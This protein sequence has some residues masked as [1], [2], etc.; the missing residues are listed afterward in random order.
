MRKEEVLILR[1]QIMKAAQQ[2]ETGKNMVIKRGTNIYFFFPFPILLLKIRCLSE[3]CYF[4][5][6]RLWV[7]GWHGEVIEGSVGL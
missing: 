2:K 5:F 4:C 6:G 3:R 7:A 1:T